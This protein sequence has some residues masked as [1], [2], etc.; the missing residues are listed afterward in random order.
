MLDPDEPAARGKAR[1]PEMLE[2]QRRVS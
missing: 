2:A 1:M